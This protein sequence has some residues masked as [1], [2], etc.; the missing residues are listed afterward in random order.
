MGELFRRFWL[1]AMLPSELPKPDCPPVRLRA[2]DVNTAV[3]D[4]D[5]MIAS[6]GKGLRAE[7]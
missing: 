5:A 4:F 2:M 1:P 3:D 6:H 7:V